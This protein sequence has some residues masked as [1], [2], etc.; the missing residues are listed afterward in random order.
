MTTDRDGN[1]HPSLPTAPDPSP[2]SGVV[3]GQLRS[4][5]VGL[6][7]GVGVI[8]VF[9][10]MVFLVGGESAKEI[11]HSALRWRYLPGLLGVSAMYYWRHRQSENETRD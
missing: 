9:T 2:L 4:V 11:F 1:E 5:A 10:L 7:A 8:A 6:S 3:R